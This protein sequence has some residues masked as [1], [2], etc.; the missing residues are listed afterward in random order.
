MDAD[1]DYSLP[2]WQPRSVHPG[3]IYMHAPEHTNWRNMPNPL[4]SWALEH[5]TVPKIIQSNF[6]DN[7]AD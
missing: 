7:V 4:Y 3:W 1:K 5:G 2:Q 6:Y